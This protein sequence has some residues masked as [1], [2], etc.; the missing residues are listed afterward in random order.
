MWQGGCIYE[1]MVVDTDLGKFKAEN[2]KKNPSMRR[3]GG[4]HPIPLLAKEWPAFG[5]SGDR[6]VGFL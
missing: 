6:R 4:E 1:V 3:G 2:K 5:S